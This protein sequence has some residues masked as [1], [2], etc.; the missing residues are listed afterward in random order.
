MVLSLSGI[1]GSFYGYVILFLFGVLASVVPFPGTSV[2]VASYAALD[3]TLGGLIFLWL[4]VAVAG[5][6]GDFLVYLVSRK[7]SE[8][9]KRYLIKYKWYNK[10]EKKARDSLNKHEFSFVF[11]SRFLLTGMDQ[12]I[13]YISGFEKLNIGKFAIAAFLG[14]LVYSAIYVSAGYIFKD[15]WAEVISFV[16]YSLAAIVFA[17]IA[18]YILYRIIKFYRKK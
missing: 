18:I 6:V 2:L 12:V 8:K 1:L 10:N 16:E 11:L 3:N 17:A 4:F 13:S 14:E 9:I 7:F 5:F 15:T